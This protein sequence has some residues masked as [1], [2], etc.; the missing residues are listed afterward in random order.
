MTQNTAATVNPFTSGTEFGGALYFVKKEV[1]TFSLNGQAN[2]IYYAWWNSNAWVAGI[3][4][5]VDQNSWS[6]QLK[7]AYTAGVASAGPTMLPATIDLIGRGYPY[8]Q[9]LNS[10]DPDGTP[11]VYSNL[12]G[13]GSPHYAPVTAIPGMSLSSIGSISIPGG[14]GAGTTSAL[15]LGRY[16]YKV[17]VTDGS[18]GSAIRDVLVVVADPIGG[19]A[20]N[21]PVLGNIGPKTINV[22]NNLS[23]VV[24]GT[25]PDSGQTLTVRAQL[26]PSGSSFPQVSGPASGTSSTFSWTPPSGSEGTYNVNF[27]VYDSAAATLIDSELVTITVTGDN[28][29]PVLAAIGNKTVANGSTLTFTA[30][31]VD[32]DVGQTVSYQ[33]FNAPAGATINPS[34]GDF[35]WT[36]AVGQYNAT[37]SNVTIRSS[38]N[39]TPSL[40]DEES[41]AITV[42]AGNNPPVTSTASL[43]ITANVGQLVSFVVSGTDANTTQTLAL[44]CSAGLPSGATFPTVTG[45]AST[46]V[47]STFSWTPG[48]GS[49]GTTSLV[50]FLTQDNGSPALNHEIIVS[51]FVTS[52]AA[53]QPIPSGL[54]DVVTAAFSP[55]A[56]GANDGTQ[57]DILGRGG[58]LAANGTLG[59]PGT[60]KVGVGGVT[61][62]PNNFQG[63]WKDNGSGLKRLVRSG[64]TAP[65]TGGALFNAIPTIPVPGLNATGD[66]TLL[67]A[68]RIGSG[69]GVTASD[70]TAMWS[71]V[72]GNGLQLLMRENDPVPGISGAFIG[73]FGYGSYATATT[74]PGTGEAILAI[75]MKGTTTDSALLR[76]SI[77]GPAAS[78][79]SIVAREKATAPGTAEV[80]GPLHSTLGAAT[81]MDTQGNIVFEAQI[82]PSGKYGIWYQA[83]A[84]SLTKVVTTS[85]TAPGTASA[86]FSALEMPSM[87]SAGTF[88]FRGVLNANGDNLDNDRN[89]GIWRGTQAGGVTPVIRRGDPALPGMPVGSKV[90]NIW[91][92][93]LNQNNRGAWRGWVD[94]AGDGISAFPADTYGIY[95]DIGGTLRLLISVNDT[96]PGTGGA[97]L[98]SVDHPHVSGATAG[99]EHVAFLGTLSGVGVSAGVND[100]AI[101]R[102]DNGGAPVLLL[103]TGAN[104]S[105]SQGSK[106]VD[107]IDL[108]GSGMDIRP[109]ELPVMDNNGR[110]LMIITY[111]DGTTAQVIAP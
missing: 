77:T 4:N 82:R 103:R 20:N 110:V 97:T 37:F 1:F 94:T 105:T 12:L 55:S 46:G 24:S 33:L 43:S 88:A 111:T 90:G 68:L 89:D 85:E 95:T 31:A 109:W 45:S 67:S 42:G 54:G 65:G 8:S 60:L 3:Q 80:F 75:K 30:S 36:P 106:T 40:F 14:T 44:S 22:G 18:G 49:V 64:D 100:K 9:N 23:F 35:S 15:N 6:V 47:S 74:G 38:D 28:N 34:T 19:S 86:T 32:P 69:S 53:P 27:E 98:A 16:G 84:G 96:A 13:S 107:D 17:E 7:I 50:R 52:G 51:I 29:P 78:T 72:G 62:I 92:G 2:G 66:V 93:W 101:W 63:Y 79:V 58:Y 87:G 102:S 48:A 25:D 83:V 21:P 56:T 99:N 57:F 70:D 5:A 61:E 10:V 91:N 76:H 81:R 59:V 73:S 108:P 71:E 104:M 26:L 41:I 11:V 39:G